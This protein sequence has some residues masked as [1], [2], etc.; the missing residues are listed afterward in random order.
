MTAIFRGRNTVHTIRFV[1][2]A[3]PAN[4]MSHDSEN[5]VRR[6]VWRCAILVF[7]GSCAGFLCKF[8]VFDATSGHKHLTMH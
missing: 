4:E 2:V 7:C 1:R 5:G 3:S 6:D 8:E